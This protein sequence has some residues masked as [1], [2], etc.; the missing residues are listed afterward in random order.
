VFN[1][2]SSGALPPKRILREAIKI[3]DK[4]LEEFEEQIKVKKIA[5]D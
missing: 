3:L 1:I 2:E 4:R 5:E